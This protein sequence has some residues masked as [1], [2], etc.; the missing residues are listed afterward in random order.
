[1]I[2]TIDGPAGAGKSSAA[3]MLARRLA[4]DFLDTGAMYRAVALA[5]HRAGIDP[6]D[7]AGM[8][9]LLQGMRLEFSSEGVL[10][11]G[12][13]V[14]QAIRTPQATAASSVVAALRVVRQQLAQWQRDFAQGRNIV[15]EGRDQGTYVFPHAECKFF[16]SADPLERARRRHQELLVR[17]ADR[18]LEQILREQHERDA[19][20]AARDFAPMQPA[21]DAVFLDS[22][23]LSLEEVV[24]RMEEDVRRKLD[25]ERH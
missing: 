16:L 25:G 1:M 11:N 3:R 21:S 15:T 10:L 22:T 19:R 8:K 9:T 24:A 6:A 12:E 2:V 14:T 20:D 4:F 18:T 23:R 13:D 17:G 7:D 5:A